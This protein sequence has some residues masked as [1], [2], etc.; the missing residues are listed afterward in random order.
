MAEGI[1]VFTQSSIRMEREQVIYFD[2]FRINQEF[3]D[4]D[5]IFI[6]HNH[7]DHFSLEDIGRVAKKDTKIVLPEKMRKDTKRLNFSEENIFYVKPEQQYQIGE[8]SVATVPSYNIIKPFHPKSC[9]WVGYILTIQGV[10]YYIAGDTDL[11]QEIKE[12]ECEV[13]FLPIGGIYTMNYKKAAELANI[14][15]PKVVIP[16]HYG[17][18]IGRKED[19]I[20][21]RELLGAGIQCQLYI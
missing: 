10:R 17:S 20:R 2:P 12:V 11:T 5:L 14:I 13:A 3:Q 15:Q 9:G 7:Y 19:G 21:F 16:V 18:I 4:A 8:I 1:N 6:T